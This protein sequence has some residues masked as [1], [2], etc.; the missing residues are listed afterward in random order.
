VFKLTQ[1]IAM[2]LTVLTLVPLGAHFFALPNK[3]HLAQTDYFIVQ[4]IYR[5]W[6]LFGLVMIGAVLA[7][8]ALAVLMRRDGVAFVLVVLNL[9]CLIVT[10]LV[11]F[12]FTYPANEATNNWTVIPADWQSL[13]WQWEASHAV[14]AVLAFGGFCALTWSLLLA[15]E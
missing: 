2:V 8:L 7:N 1:F 14:N 12:A 9:L 13:R 15:Q 6:A 10:L 11:F 4:N 5:G 3:I